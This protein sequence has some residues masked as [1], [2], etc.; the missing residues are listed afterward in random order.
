MSER[1]WLILILIATTLIGWSYAVANPVFEGGDEM[2]HYPMVQH[3]SEGNPLPVQVF[4]PAEAGPWKQQA[5]QPPLYYYF[6]AW[7]TGWIDTSD[8]LEIRWQNPHV[9]NG[10]ITSDGNINLTVHNP[11]WNPFWGT[12]LAVR[13]VRFVSVLMGTVAVYF[14]YRIGKL[15]AP[16]RSD[17]ALGAA[18]IFAFLP[19]RLF[20]SAA[21]NNDNGII[22]LATMAVFLLIQYVDSAEE[23]P[24]SLPRGGRSKPP[25]LREGLGEGSSQIILIGIVIG[26][27]CLTKIIGV[28]LLP[29]AFGAIFLANWKTRPH[30][31]SFWQQL[32]AVIGRTLLQT[33][34][35][36]AIT[37][38]IAGWWYIRNVRLYDDWR[39]WSAFIAVLGQRNQPATLAQLWDERFGFMM[40]YWGLF[41]GVNVPLPIPVYHL[42]NTIA[43][44]GV[45]GFIGYLALQIR[46]FFGQQTTGD[47]R[48][49]TQRATRN[50]EN[51]LSSLLNLATHHAPIIICL[52]WMAAVVVGLIDWATT[53][54]SSQG[55]LV[56]GALQAELV[57]LTLGLVGWMG[58]KFGRIIIASLAT[59]LF[60]IAAVAPFTIIRPT[61]ALDTTTS[62]PTTAAPIATFG[63]SI[64]LRSTLPNFPKAIAAGDTFDV[65]LDWQ[66]VQPTD[67]NW[68]VFV[69]LNDPILNNPIAQRD[70]YLAQGLLGTSFAEQ[71]TVV[72]NC[73]TL[74]VDQTAI[75]PAELSLDVGLY[76][77]SNFERLPTNSGADHISLGTIELQPNGTP[78]LDAPRANFGDEILLADFSLDQRRV[79]RGEPLM[80]TLHLAAPQ[81]LTTDYSVTAQVVSEDLTDTTRWA[82]A[83]RF[84]GSTNWQPNEL[85][86]VQLELPVK[87]ETQAG[88][89][90]LIL[91]VYTQTDAGFTN[92]SLI[93]ADGRITN[94]NL[95]T[96]TKVR[97]DE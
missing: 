53:T 97:I 89:Y 5:S 73:Y 40:A 77:F 70:M 24:P 23:P 86:T 74:Q 51:T 19:M 91:G 81:Q 85:Q 90:R 15:A 11:N 82:A 44:L 47:R 32:L 66:I 7:L 45:F 17:V 72:Q 42:L 30:D 39:G 60:I 35:V 4:D 12:M 63:D 2:W 92:L 59:F 38:I 22:M 41:G 1:R 27:A 54:W 8:M 56:F 21:V 67:R 6:N 96:L 68:S 58:E 13:L 52:V 50:I 49:T 28:G 61:Y 84:L 75:A 10:I 36:A 18:A 62:E 25:S 95:L 69:H 65:C 93:S 3:L 16:N 80:L 9:D 79:Q 94:D 33:A 20:V 29:L 26:L 31:I 48:Q 87:A 55:R 37:L 64:A 43:A 88:V 78:T 34:I 83:D 71:G 14:T 57:L 76:D 46:N